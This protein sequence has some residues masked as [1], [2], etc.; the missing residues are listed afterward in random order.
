[1]TVT[2]VSRPA[3]SPASGDGHLAYYLRHGISPVRYHVEEM[4][5]HLDRRD[6]LYRSLGLPPIAFKGADVLEVAPGSG[7]NSL[8][9]ATCL[10]AALTLLEPNPAARHDIEAAY[11]ALRQP[12]TQPVLVAQTLEAFCPERQF[13]IVICENWLGALP[14]ELELLRKLA[15]LVAPGGAM[16]ITFVPLSGFFPNV[17]R[18]LLALRVGYPFGDFSKATAEFAQ[19]FG[20]HL[21]TLA[22]MTRSHRDWVQDC[23]LNPH[24]LNVA[25]PLDAVLDTLG[26]RMEVLGTFPRFTD[27]WRWFKGLTGAVRQFNQ[28]LVDAARANLHNFVDY[29]KI[30]PARDPAT[31]A[32]LDAAFAAVHTLALSW[33]AA[34]AAGDEA[35]LRIVAGQIG[36]RI[37][38]IRIAI[39]PIDP[40]IAAAIEELHQTWSRPHLAPSD[41]RNMPRFGGL[42]GRETLYLSLTRGRGR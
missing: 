16:V 10:P 7:Q 9:V 36:Q 26:D 17:M 23:I 34:R 21:A 39:R 33:Q 30:F 1:M 31:N 22:H 8:Y 40:D 32:P 27:D 20:T 37:D 15:T 19:I 11:A 6:S 35:R 3:P 24:Y 5:A 12:H 25:L 4:A 18:K 2:D 13:D 41:I 38:E 14:H 29:R 28:R 42:F